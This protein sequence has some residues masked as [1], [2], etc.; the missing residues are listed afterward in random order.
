MYEILCI[1]S[2]PPYQIHKEHKHEECMHGILRTKDTKDE[3]TYALCSLCSSLCVL[4]VPL[5]TANRKTQEEGEFL[6]SSQ[7]LP[8][9][10]QA[11]INLH[12]LNSQ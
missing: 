3:I 12:A 11:Q 4:C 2:V 8:E 7:I 6:E 1:R 10:H 9:R 5:K